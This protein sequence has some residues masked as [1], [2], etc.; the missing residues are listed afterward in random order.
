M[1]RTLVLAALL[2][3][4]LPA[5]AGTLAG[6]TLPDTITVGSRTL[7]LNGLGLRTK[8]FVKVYVAGLY[9]EKKSDDAAA[10]VQSDSAKRI[11]L[12]FIR[13][14]VGR[15]QMTEAFDEALKANA[16]DKAASLQAECKQFLG[17]LETMREKEQFAVTYVPGEGTT[18]T[19][20][21]K[22]KLTIPGQAFGQVVFSMWL[23]PKPPNAGLKN[24]LLGKK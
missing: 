5:A 12:Q 18:V 19:V 6:V 4:A 11:V 14:E 13:S 22:D 21:G 8:L 1:R 15:E 23:G 3:V 17:A 7:V 20:R 9:L 24:G 2:A 16:P 10:I